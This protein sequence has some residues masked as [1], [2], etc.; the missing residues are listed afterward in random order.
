[1]TND[2]ENARPSFVNLVYF[3]NITFPKSGLEK[4]KSE[5]LVWYRI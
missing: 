2:S 5:L 3:A 1:M 4:N